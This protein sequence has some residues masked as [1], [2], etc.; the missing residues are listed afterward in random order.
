[1]MAGVVD[2]ANGRFVLS[3]NWKEL[4]APAAPPPSCGGSGGG[5]G[6]NGGGPAD[7]VPPSGNEPV[8]ALTL[9]N[10]TRASG[11]GSPVPTRKTTPSM[12]PLGFCCCWLENGDDWK[13]IRMGATR[14]TSFMADLLS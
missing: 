13:R 12:L 8:A 1:M 7:R 6:A 14:P 2:G 3:E 10:V 11:I 5:G 9:V 4:T